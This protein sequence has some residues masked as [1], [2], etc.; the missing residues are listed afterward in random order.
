MYILLTFWAL[1]AVFYRA[2]DWNCTIEHVFRRRKVH[3]IDAALITLRLRSGIRFAAA[4]AVPALVLV[5]IPDYPI[6]VARKVFGVL[7]RLFRADGLP[8]S[9]IRTGS[10]QIR[11]WPGDSSDIA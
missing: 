9:P 3:F 8:R 7:T 5:W 4:A 6:F 10:G 2:L 11:K 1:L